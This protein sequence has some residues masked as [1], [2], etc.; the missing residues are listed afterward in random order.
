MSYASCSN[1]GMSWLTSLCMSFAVAKVSDVLRVL[2]VA[3]LAN[4]D[5]KNRGK[6]FLF[7]R[8]IRDSAH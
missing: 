3:K 7:M 5:S 8:L 6:K 1:A 2:A 4:I